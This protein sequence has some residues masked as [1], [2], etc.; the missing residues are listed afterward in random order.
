M[1]SRLLKQR[2]SK[3]WTHFLPVWRVSQERFARRDVASLRAVSADFA[4]T[5]SK[6]RPSVKFAF[7]LVLQ[8]WSFWDVCFRLEERRAKSKAEKPWERLSKAKLNKGTNA[9]GG[10]YYYY[11]KK[12]SGWL[13]YWDSMWRDCW[14]PT[15]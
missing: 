11:G 2:E 13:E 12:N 8:P 9:F 10:T 6:E 4:Q 14:C 1:C 5:V 3:E 15:F 7:V